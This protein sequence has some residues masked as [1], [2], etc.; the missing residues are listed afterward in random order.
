MNTRMIYVIYVRKWRETVEVRRESSGVINSDS[1]G[2]SESR[3][4]TAESN[5]CIL[6]P[7]I[8]FINQ[9]LSLPLHRQDFLRTAV[10][11][12]LFRFPVQE[13]VTCT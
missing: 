4:S 12:S 6:L 7:F 2:M 8:Y 13:S 1:I 11:A 10:V 5:V 9:E 3:I